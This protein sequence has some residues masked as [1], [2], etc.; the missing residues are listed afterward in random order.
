MN[1]AKLAIK[2]QAFQR[3]AIGIGLTCLTHGRVSKHGV[4]PPPLAGEPLIVQA[5]ALTCYATQSA[6]ARLADVPY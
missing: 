2:P 5:L 6:A 4:E 3:V 1:P